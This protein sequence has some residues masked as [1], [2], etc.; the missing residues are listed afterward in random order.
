MIA[1]LIILIILLPVI[2]Y[3]VFQYLVE[4]KQGDFAIA[5]VEKVY[6]DAV[7]SNHLEIDEVNTYSNRLIAIDRVAGC[8]LMIVTDDKH[9]WQRCV[10][11]DDIRSCRVVHVNNRDNGYTQKVAL[12]LQISSGEKIFYPFFDERTD[13]HRDLGR[14]TK[15]ARY[16]KQK[17]IS[18]AKWQMER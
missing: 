2:V 15:N 4:K 13:D 8:L 7:R 6:C 18:K 17:A 1:T 9:T 3:L 5:Q 10:N 11:L 14:R 12:E 16:W